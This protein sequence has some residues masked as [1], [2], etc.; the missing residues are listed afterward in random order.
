MEDYDWMIKYHPGKANVVANALSRQVQVARLMIKELHLLEKVSYWN[1]RLEPRKVILGN[2]VV[3]FTLLERIKESQEK[4]S[5]VQKWVEKVK[6]GEKLDFTLGLNG[7]LRFRNWIVV[8]KNEGLKKEI[9]AET[10]R[11]KFTVHPRGNK[12]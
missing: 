8:P 5:E 9:L 3:N 7:I 11:L 10:H 6:K 2:I 4:D 12:M 1:S